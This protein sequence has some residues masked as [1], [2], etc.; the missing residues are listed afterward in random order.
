[1]KSK[2]NQPA[3]FLDDYIHYARFRLSAKEQKLLV[4]LAQLLQS[5]KNQGTCELPA[6]ELLYVLDFTSSKKPELNLQKL[7]NFL[8]ALLNKQIKFTTTS[9]EPNALTS[10]IQWISGY[11]FQSSSE[12]DLM[13]EFGFSP[14]ISSYL[15]SFQEKIN[16]SESIDVVSLKSGYAIAIFQLCRQYANLD[17]KGHGNFTFSL[18]SLKH[19][20]GTDEKYPDFRNFRRKVLDVAK[21]E[22]NDHTPLKIDYKFGKSGRQIS[23]IEFHVS[24]KKKRKKE[25]TQTAEPLP[26]KFTAPKSSSLSSLPEAMSRAA[27]QLIDYGLDEKFVLD[28]LPKQIVGSELRG[29]EDFLVQAMIDFF[30]SKTNAQTQTGKIKA[31]GSWIKNGRFQSPGVLAIL[32][33]RVVNRKKKLSETERYYRNKAKGMT[34]MQ[35]QQSLLTEKKHKPV[36]IP[37]EKPVK[38]LSSATPVVEK[39]SSSKQVRPKFDYELF[40]KE[41]S[42]EYRR[43]QKERE[44]AFA[45]LKDQP[46]YALLLENSVKAYCENNFRRM[47]DEG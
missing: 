11:V 22:I 8:A 18:D 7:D 6:V 24:E 4:H 32:T 41:N 27:N 12:G 1:M 5:N 34:S 23:Q 25:E 3:G 47:R 15:S 26:V 10:R 45:H 28:E 36:P 35:F 37:L 43:I 9:D 20:L 31:L 42:K 17:E 40:K 44:L 29:F 39:K 30:E 19:Q 13:I 14:L 46:N 2:K 33:E 16:R 21:K 38:P